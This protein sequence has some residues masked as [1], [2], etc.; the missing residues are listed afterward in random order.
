MKLHITP[1]QNTYP[2]LYK[3]GKGQQNDLREGIKKAIEDAD[4]KGVVQWNNDIMMDL[5]F[6]LVGG[7]FVTVLINVLL[8]AEDGDIHIRIDHLKIHKDETEANKFAEGR[9][10]EYNKVL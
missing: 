3:L 4:K 5:D 1:R 9:G 6:R 2:A 10:K 7:K 8:N